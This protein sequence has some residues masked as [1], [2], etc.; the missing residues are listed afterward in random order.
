MKFPYL[1]R[2]DIEDPLVQENFLRI[3]D[4]HGSDP[5]TRCGFQFLSIPIPSAV[6]NFK[7]AHGLNFVPM[8][9][10]I[11]H[12]LSNATIVLNYDKFD[13]ISLDITSSAATTL[14]L[15]VGRYV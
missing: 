1:F 6:T 14:R 9:V 3:M 4:Y 5:Y 11:T 8:D 13:A 7:F 12:N 2:K 15:F 10:I